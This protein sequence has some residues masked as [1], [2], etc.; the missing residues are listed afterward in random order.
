MKKSLMTILIAL[1]I[2]LYLTSIVLWIAVPDNLILDLSTSLFTLLFTIG[3]WVTNKDA[4]NTYLLSRYSKK[5]FNELIGIFLILLILIF[6]NYLGFKNSY[7]RDLSKEKVHTLSD[8]TKTILRDLKKPVTFTLFSKREHWDSILFLLRLYKNSNNNILINAVDIEL[9]PQVARAQNL[10]QFP[11]VMIDDGTKKVFV[12][13]IDELNL[14]NGFL[15]LSSTKQVLIYYSIGHGEIEM[16]NK[17]ESG[18]SYFYE[19]MKSA[20]YNLNPIFLAKMSEIPKD[21]DLLLLIGPA[22]GFLPNEIKILDNY[23]KNGGRLL[24]T[25]SPDF[26]GDRLKSLRELLVKYGVKINNDIVVDQL[27][28][29]HGA[30]ATVPVIEKFSSTHKIMEKFKG[31]IIFPMAS[32]IDFIQ[33]PG[34]KAETL[35]SSSA[36]P[37]SWAEQDLGQVRLGKAVYDAKDH[38]GPSTLVGIISDETGADDLKTKIAIFTSSSFLINGYA[39]QGPNFNLLLN[40]VDWLVGNEGIMSLNRPMVTHERIMMSSP[41]IGTIFYFSVVFL[42]LIFLVLSFY[43]YRR[44]LKL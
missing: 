18:A 2:V 30:D 32:S 16:E 3:L 27:S 6:V 23:L 19:M 20:N 38:K 7:E 8:Q 33:T 10:T 4:L 36:F 26:K 22:D 44:K 34:I 42:P 11:A 31:T 9:S 13:L 25:Y 21:C 41:Q 14:T 37:G 35:V 43:F 28:T 24:L 5:F 1:N 29:V 17:M 12:T 15:K 39:S 40:T